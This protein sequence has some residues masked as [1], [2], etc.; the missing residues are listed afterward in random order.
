MGHDSMS[1]EDIIYYISQ[2]REQKLKQRNSDETGSRQCG[3]KL[4]LDL[5]EEC[6]EEEIKYK[7][8]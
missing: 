6:S 2:R 7:L 4:Q 1:S 8:L 5:K 3:R